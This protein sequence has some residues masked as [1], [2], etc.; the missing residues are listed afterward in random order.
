MLI[1]VNSFHT[2]KSYSR[3]IH[4]TII[5]PTPWL[6]LPPCR[7]GF[8]RRWYCGVQSG[9]GVDFSPSNSLLPLLNHSIIVTHAFMNSFFLFVAFLHLSLSR[10]S[11]HFPLSHACN[12]P[13]LPNRKRQSHLKNTWWGL[14]LSPNILD[15]CVT[16]SHLVTNNP[17]VHCS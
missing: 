8:V 11:V 14:E 3:N 4:F 5:W 17:S 15:H 12:M 6:S 2:P 13:S 10:T 7:S 1:T 9:L 16:C